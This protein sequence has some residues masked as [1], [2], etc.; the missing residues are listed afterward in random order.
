MDWSINNKSIPLNE[1][2]LVCFLQSARGFIFRVIVKLYNAY[3]LLE[4]ADGTIH[5]TVCVRFS[6][7]SL[8]IRDGSGRALYNTLQLACFFGDIVVF[9]LRTFMDECNRVVDKTWV[10]IQ[11]NF[12]F[13]TQIGKH[14]PISWAPA[15]VQA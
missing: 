7:L 5:S 2:T 12:V 13:V 14:V 11:I 4:I 10:H 1:F 15:A 8:I 9:V 6:A 3:L